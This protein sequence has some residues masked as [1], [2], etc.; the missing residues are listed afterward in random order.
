MSH[1]AED[2]LAATR[3]VGAAGDSIEIE[4][5]I[6]REPRAV[7]RAI[8]DAA[9]RRRW[10]SYCDLDA[11]L[12][13]RFEER[14]QN[15]RGAVTLTHGAIEAINLERRLELS[16]RDEDWAAPTRVVLELTPE[17]GGTLVRV[18]HSGWQAI[19]G[20]R[21]E[22]RDAHRKGWIHHLANLKTFVEWPATAA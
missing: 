1:D 11:R 22:L 10:W 12:G 18:R 21:R 9:E 4:V 19:E 15:D 7:W 2:R 17:A 8:V 14:W 13:G 20:E 16:W 6:T 3:D 5:S